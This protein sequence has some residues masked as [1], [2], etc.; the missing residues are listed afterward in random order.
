MKRS[1][2]PIHDILS[3][4]SCVSDLGCSLRE[5]QRNIGGHLHDDQ[6]NSALGALSTTNMAGYAA[7]EDLCYGTG[8]TAFSSLFRQGG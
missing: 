4:F 6:H 8:M 1:V 3:N 2:V 5:N 7:A